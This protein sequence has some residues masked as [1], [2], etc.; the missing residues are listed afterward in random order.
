M[1]QTPWWSASVV[2]LLGLWLAPTRAVAW[3]TDG[4]AIVAEVA[5]RRL[6]AR[7]RAEIERLLGPGHSLASESAWGD[8]VRGDRPETFKWHFVDIPLG[9]RGYDGA[10]DCRATPK[11]DCIVAALERV[12]QALRYG[13][14]GERRE[15]LRW[16]VHLV[17]DLHQ[18][19][20]AIAEAKGGNDIVVQVSI[21]GL[22]C[23]QCKPMPS[24]NLH[25]VWDTS[26][27][28]A[29]TRS[30][31]EYAPRL[32]GGWLE[33]VEARAT[34]SGTVIDWV[35]ETHQVARHVWTWTPADHVI[36]EGYYRAALPVLDRQLGRAG[37]RLAAFL[38]D[39][40]NVPARARGR[41]PGTGSSPAHG[42]A[43]VRSPA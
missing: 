36:D 21:G 24:Q 7:T 13:G 32:E 12:R 23:P 38:D 3:G 29:T 40:F 18:P 30:W 37:V 14:E 20:H 31:G 16:A 1:R 5:Q 26:L 43:R 11:G 17:A 27:I 10:R 6:A 9:E 2:A 8:E 39:V 42:R 4:H 19:M 33:S 22:R 41:A 34:S 15:A 28:V 25:A 35:N